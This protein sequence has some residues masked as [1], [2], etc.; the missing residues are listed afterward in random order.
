MVNRGS[1]KAMPFILCV[2]IRTERGKTMFEHEPTNAE[3]EATEV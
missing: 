3:I 2:R 1:N